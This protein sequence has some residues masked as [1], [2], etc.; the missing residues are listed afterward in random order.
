VRL[1][2][3][4]PRYT[5]N[6]HSEFG[7]PEHSGLLA[8]GAWSLASAAEPKGY[9]SPG[10]YVGE[11]GIGAALLRAGQVL[12]ASELV[13][14]A[15]ERARRIAREP[16][17]SP[18]LFNGT[19]GCL[20]FELLLWDETADTEH[21]QS[22]IRA[23]ETLLS[24]AEGT[25]GRGLRWTIPSGYGELS[26]SAY[27]GYAHGAAGIGDALLDLFDVCREE[28]FLNAAQKVGCWLSSLSVAVLDD[29]T[30]ISWPTIQGGPPSAPFWCHGAT[31]VGRFFLHLAQAG[32]QPEASDLAVR[33]ARAA[34][35]GARYAG[36]T[37]C[38]GLAGNIEFLLDMFQETHDCVYLKEAQLLAGLLEAFAEERNGNL[39]W[40]SESPSTFS[41]D[42]M[43]GYAG[44]ATC[45]LRLSAPERLA[46]LLSRRGFQKEWGRPGSLVRGA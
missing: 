46:H 43:V 6:S 5:R 12:G 7:V 2:C 3:S 37:Q 17:V 1:C 23:G 38:H 44:V 33:A 36:P 4:L 35:R 27:L 34:G 19:A 15:V 22:A 25:G 26:G 30:G 13:D 21:L 14:A 29:E 40:P 28:R 16:Y 41:P 24:S 32:R 39:M 20:R 42:F 18:D 31:G 8:E 10:L 9:F 11:A 45:F